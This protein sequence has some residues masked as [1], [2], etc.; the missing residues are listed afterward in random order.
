MP[1]G[2]DPEKIKNMSPEERMK[3]FQEMQKMQ[4]I[5]KGDGEEKPDK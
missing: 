2:M 4:G 5:P 1:G 3:F